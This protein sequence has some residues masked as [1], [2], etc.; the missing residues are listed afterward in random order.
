MSA[1]SGGLSVTGVF[2]SASRPTGLPTICS[3]ARVL[4]S[5]SFSATS[6][7]AITRSKR[8]WAS[9]E[10]VMVAVPTMKLRLACSSCSATAVF[11][12]DGG[13]IRPR[14]QHVEVAH[15]D[16]GHEVL[17]GESQLVLCLP[18]LDFG[19]FVD[20]LVL[21]AVQRLGDVDPVVVVVEVAP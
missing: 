5:R 8:A 2:R 19:L 17:G 21:S 3:S 7:W 13:E 20:G 14:E 4:T 18:Y 6:S 15:G 11:W 9:R 16:P 12:E 1:G 10:S